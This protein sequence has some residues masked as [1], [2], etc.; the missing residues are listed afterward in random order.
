MSYNIKW[1]YHQWSIADFQREASTINCDPEWQRG[2]V[3]TL[4]HT[5]STPSKAQSI[6]SS[7][8]SGLDI[9]EIKLCWYKGNRASVDGGNRKRAILAFLR[10]EF[11]LHKK[12]K[13]GQKYFKDLTSDLQDLFYDYNMRVI[14]YDDLPANMIGLTFRTTN[15]VTE[16]NQQEMRNSYGEDPLATFIRRTV[17]L[18]PEISN[19]THELYA[20]KSV[21]K[22]GDR[23]RYLAFNNHRLKMED[24]LARI[25]HRIIEG[26]DP[27]KKYAGPSPDKALNEMYDTV[28]PRW[29]N[30][31]DEQTKIEKKTK[32]ALDFFQ[33]V[34]N[35][36]N[37]RRGGQGLTIGQF[38]LLTRVYFYMKDKYGEF[39]VENYLAFWDQ[40]ARAFLSVECRK[41]LIKVEDDNGNLV[42][43]D[44]TVGEAFRGYL[45][46][47]IPQEWKYFDSL[48]WFLKVFDPLNVITV[49]DPKRCFSAKEIE[50]CL[51][52][53]NWTDFIDGKPLA[54]QDAVGAHRVA[55]TNGGR[56]TK[57]NLVVVS[58]EHNT[59]MGSMD[60][61][62][63]KRWFEQQLRKKA[64]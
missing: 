1:Q 28:G 46:F 12:S 45:S 33:K 21:T 16:V 3:D 44:R 49:K 58:A 40:F 31:P 39:K 19:P 22:D 55:H 6:I 41:D 29:E 56:T 32:E 18:I 5:S 53:Q 52:H 15:T 60:V 20:I 42:D 37:T 54:L 26:Q 27:K 23:Y 51:I 38:S 34:A 8:L 17:R 10:N 64:S 7:I 47:D 59:A 48:N 43:G 4:F 13:W 25:V 61:D 36:A 24:Q 9:G 14:I 63:Y 2:N 30:N 62:S 11:P 57:S 50:D 35:A